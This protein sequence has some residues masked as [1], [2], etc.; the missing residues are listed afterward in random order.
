MW[1]MQSRFDPKA[2]GRGALTNP[3]NRYEAFERE[4]FDD[5]WDIDDERGVL[6]T[7][8][9]DEPVGK[10]ITEN[11]SPDIPFDR[12]INP[13]RGCEHGCIYCYARP[14]HSYLGY[15]AGLEFE[16]KLIARM[17]SSEA[18][19]KAFRAKNYV[20]KVIC[21]GSNTDPYQPIEKDRLVARALLE[22]FRAYRHPVAVLTKG[23]LIERDIDILADLARDNLVRVGVSV[24]TLDPKVSRVMEPRVP[25]PERRIKTIERLSG[26]GIPT[27]V[28]ISPLIPALTDHELEA[29]IK[30]A[31]E[32]GAIA[33]SFIPLR[34]PL[35]VA[36]LF[37]EWL[38]QHFPDRAERVMGRV[39]EVQGG[40][41]YDS[42]W[43]VRMR[44]QG[45]WADLMHKRFKLATD[46]HGLNRKVQELRSDLFA[47]PPK[48]GDQLSLF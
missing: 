23:S 37:K 6:R 38:T 35:E 47:V 33:A 15:S 20:P 24:T 25:M 22:V 26:A 41:D 34:L 13:Y 36:P 32:A 2:K 1:A 31:A 3:H 18:L 14:S 30:R 5:G 11:R 42:N 21:I 27:R 28:M 44:G 7:E 10:V 29:I 9:R 17:N 39:R 40:K 4:G 16:T 43:M 48:A 45:I 46:K 12:S 19:E 8:V